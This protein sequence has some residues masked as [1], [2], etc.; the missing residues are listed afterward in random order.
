MCGVR[1]KS[2]M[3]FRTMS[4]AD[5]TQCGYLNK[6]LLLYCQKREEGAGQHVL[7]LMQ[8]NFGCQ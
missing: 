5:D 7:P 4:V 1:D 6:I 2:V 8:N 3:C